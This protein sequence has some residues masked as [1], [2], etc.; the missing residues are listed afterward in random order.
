MVICADGLSGIKEAIEA[1]YPETEY[2]R[3]IVHQ[4]RNTLK[5][6]SFKDKR[7]FS[8]DLRSIYLAPN[9]EQGREALE[10]VKDKWEE[11]YPNSIKSCAKT[12]SVS[13]QPLL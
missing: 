8:G 5:Y 3:C 7:A 1:A 6:V 12:T 2:Q 4:I 13:T 11:K 9:E 10:Y